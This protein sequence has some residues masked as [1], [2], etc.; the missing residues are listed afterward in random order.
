MDVFALREKL[1]GDY[2]RYAES[3]LTIRDERIDSH[4]QA[5]MGEGLLWPDPPLQLNPAFEPGGFI[6]ELADEGVLQDECRRIFRAAKSDTDPVGR[7]IGLHK[8]QA[9]AIRAASTG[10]N[11]VLTTGT[12]SGKS[13]AYIVPIVDYVL[14]NGAGNGRIKAIVVYPMNALANSQEFSGPWPAM[15][16]S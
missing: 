13:L 9:D 1:V 7:S 4:V 2:R 16:A 6:D 3:F 10:A 8:H 5:K 14:R 12:G 11:Y 15:R